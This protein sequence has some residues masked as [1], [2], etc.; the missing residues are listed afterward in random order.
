MRLDVPEA[1]IILGILAGVAWA[2]YNRIHPH[3]EVRKPG[4]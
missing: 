3:V 1:L 4:R 2:I